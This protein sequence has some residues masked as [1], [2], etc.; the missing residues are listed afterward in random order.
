[1]NTHYRRLKPS[2]VEALSGASEYA[3]LA[4]LNAVRVGTNAGDLIVQIG[5]EDSS[6][7]PGTLEANTI[8]EMN[9]DVKAD[10]LHARWV[11]TAES[12]PGYGPESQIPPGATVLETGINPHSFA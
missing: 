8:T 10:V 11:S 4:S 3:R 2:E 5:G 9:P 1:M 7:L 12:D 6:K